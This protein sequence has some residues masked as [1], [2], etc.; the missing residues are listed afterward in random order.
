MS[1]QMLGKARLSQAQVWRLRLH[2]L[3]YLRLAVSG[4]KLGYLGW[5]G[6]SNV[7]DEAVYEGYRVALSKTQAHATPLPT[8]PTLEKLV[9]LRGGRVPPGPGRWRDDHRDRRVSQ[10]RDDAHRARV[11]AVRARSRRRG[12]VVPRALCE[13]AQSRADTLA[14]SPGLLFDKVTV[15][16]PRSREILASLGVEAEVVGDAAL[17]LGAERQQRQTPSGAWASIWGLPAV[18]GEAISNLC[19]MRSSARLKCCWMMAGT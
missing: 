13:G 6:H 18:S 4:C 10:G 7:G 1:Q 19:F 16:G 2:N 9:R 17:L 11:N 8:G 3:R 5:L 15:R 12:S 14:G